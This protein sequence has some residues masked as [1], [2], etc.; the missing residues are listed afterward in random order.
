[1]SYYARYIV[2]VS[3]ARLGAVRA[4]ARAL[5]SPLDSAGVRRVLTADA[6]WGI[7]ALFWISTGLVRLFAGLEKT[8]AYYLGSHLF[9]TKMVFL[10]L[11]LLL[12][13]GPIRGFIRWRAALGRGNPP[14][15]V[16]V[17]HYATISYIEA[18]LV[19]LMIIAATGM[20]R[21]YGS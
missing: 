19:V 3:S 5:Q 13:I 1:M 4:R 18:V 15:L 12:E 21:G 2:F 6:W 7:A 14:D 9:W 20:A 17:G 10:L 16:N 11:I 8:T